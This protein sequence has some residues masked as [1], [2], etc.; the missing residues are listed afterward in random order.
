MGRAAQ[1]DARPPADADPLV[2]G[3]RSQDLLEQRLLHATPEDREHRAEPGRSVAGKIVDGGHSRVRRP[4]ARVTVWGGPSDGGRGGATPMADARPRRRSSLEDPPW[5]RVDGAVDRE[6]DGAV[7]R[8]V[9][10]AGV[11][12]LVRMATPPM[13]S[14]SATAFRARGLATSTTPAMTMAAAASASTRRTAGR[15]TSGV[16]DAGRSSSAMTRLG[17]VGRGRELQAVGQLGER[18]LEVGE[19]HG[20]EGSPNW[21]RRRSRARRAGLHGARRHVERCRGLRLGQAGEVAQGD[22]RAVAVVQP[23]QS[24]AQLAGR[25]STQRQVLGRARLPTTNCRG[26]T[27][28][29]SRRPWL[30]RRLRA[31]LATICISH[32]RRGRPSRNRR[33]RNAFT[34]ASWVTSSASLSIPSPRTVRGARAGAGRPARRARRC[35]RVEPAPRGRRH[36]RCSRARATHRPSRTA[37]LRS[38]SSYTAG[39]AG[40]PGRVPRLPRCRSAAG[41]G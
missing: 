5:T 17:H 34:N 27:A 35:H 26:R 6:L 40:V 33:A 36:P 14:R 24:G 23:G 31:S 28:S 3:S 15:W 4:S 20:H 39:R 21:S 1:P 38:G 2:G 25:D 37:G 16:T 9:G 41:S 7:D 18:P 11:V 13:P 22:D 30:R 10:I 19:F 12:S 32:G 8:V 29:R